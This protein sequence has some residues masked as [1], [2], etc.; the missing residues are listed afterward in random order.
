MKKII[1]FLVFVTS[2]IVLTQQRSALGI[3][4]NEAA[5]K[6]SFIAAYIKFD[7]VDG[8]AKDAGHKGWSDVISIKHQKAGPNRRLEMMKV[9]VKK[10]KSSATLGEAFRNKKIFSRVLIHRNYSSKGKGRRVTY[11][12]F[13]LTNARVT[14]Y[15]MSKTGENVGITLNYE[16]IEWT[17]NERDAS[18]EKKRTVKYVWTDMRPLSN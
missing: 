4:E 13:E 7:G 10:D 16:K 18:G 2:F 3:V 9:Y 11:N 5:S 6:G 17:Y 8:E 15:R 14:S 12:R 1:C